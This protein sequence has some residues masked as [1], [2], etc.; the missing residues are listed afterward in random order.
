[1]SSLGLVESTGGAIAKRF[2]RERYTVCLVGR[3]AEE[4]APLVAEVE[5]ARA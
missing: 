4:R 1:V 2:A 5:Y 3:N